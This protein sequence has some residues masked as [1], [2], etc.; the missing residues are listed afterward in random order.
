MRIAPT[1]QGAF[2][3]VAGL[4]PVVHHKSFELVTGKKKEPWL[5]QTM[6][7]LIAAVGVTLLV[8]A[9]ERSRSARTLGI[10]SAAV[11]GGAD[12][13]F[14]GQRRISP[15]YLGDAAAEAALIATWLLGD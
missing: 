13:V 10:A 5:V 8:G 14:V 12:L 7:A 15:V 6:G 9:R 11:L 2:Y 3:V 4:W 1:L